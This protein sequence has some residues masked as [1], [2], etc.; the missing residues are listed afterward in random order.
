MI[1]VSIIVKEET[2]RQLKEMGTD[3]LT[4]QKGSIGIGQLK[5]KERH[6]GLED[7]T[8]M[9]LHCQ[10]IIKAVP[11]VTNYTEIKYKTNKFGN[12]IIGTT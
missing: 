5:N 6:I 7:V 12:P 4:V 9:S 2:I 11:I 1:S 8:V 10:L 3:I